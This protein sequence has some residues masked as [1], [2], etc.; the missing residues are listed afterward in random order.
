MQIEGV[1][2]RKIPPLNPLRVFEVVAR[3]ENLTLAAAELSVTQSA[4]SRQ[5]GS[6]ETYLGVELVK[7]ERYGVT[8]TRT[9]KAYAETITPAFAAIADATAKLTESQVKNILRV[10]TYTTFAAKWLITRLE[11]FHRL[12]PDV[13]VRITNAVPDV[14]FDKDAVDVAIQYGIG[15]WVGVNSDLLFLD[16]IEPVCSPSFLKKYAPNPKFPSSLLRQR[17]L[18]SRY[19]R[20]DFKDW[21]EHTELAK[22]ADGAEEMTFS[23][24]VLTWQAA[25]DGLGL[26]IGQN[27]LLHKEFEAGTLVRP[28]NRPVRTGKGYFL[29][30]PRLQRESR[31]VT[32]FRDWLIQSTRAHPGREGSDQA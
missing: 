5:L 2:M 15:K 10:R 14:D 29:V 7:R 30:R 12:N 1:L 13:N 6:L 22:E 17:Q 28:F 8:L 25:I 23:T 24:S 31:K 11:D 16:E 19:R 32:A 18:I 26:A 4:V 9:G 20:N 27:V 21:L 3:T